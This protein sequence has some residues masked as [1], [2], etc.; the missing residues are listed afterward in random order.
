VG[1]LA[2]PF[3]SRCAAAAKEQIPLASRAPVRRNSRLRKKT[4]F[5]GR[6][7][8]VSDLQAR[9]ASRQNGFAYDELVSGQTIYSYVGGN[10]LSYTDPEGLVADAPGWCQ[11]CHTPPPVY[12]GN[13]NNNGGP[14]PKPDPTEAAAG[15]Q[16]DTAI[17]QAYNNY[18]SNARMNCPNQDPDDRCKWLNDNAQ[19]FPAAAVKATSKAWGCRGS[20]WSGGNKF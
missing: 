19:Y 10:P 9:T 14:M 6:I 13:P 7:V 17:Q 8:F 4:G 11:F 16:V 3:F 1:R 15:N 18:A 12:P 5:P 2:P 20:R